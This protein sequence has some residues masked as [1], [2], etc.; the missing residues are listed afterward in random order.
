VLPSGDFA[1]VHNSYILAI[2]KIESI[3][4]NRI[5]IA[6][7]RIA[8]SDSYKAGFYQLLREKKYLI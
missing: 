2:E 1:R 6:G 3:E 4:R 8:I 7:N 5:L